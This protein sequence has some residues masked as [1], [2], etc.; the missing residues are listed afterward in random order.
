[1]H[2]AIRRYTSDPE[3]FRDLQERLESDFVPHL[4]HI[5]GF[6]SYYAIPTGPDTLSTVSV[7]E[8]KEGERESTELA[9]NF[10]K[11]NWP[12]LRVDRVSLDEGPCLVE[13]HITALV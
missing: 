1:M 13:H 6:I 11:R 9:T 7:F 3:I 12:G 10:I 8:T 2:V 4:K 5:D